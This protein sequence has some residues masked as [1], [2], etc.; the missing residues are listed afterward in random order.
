MAFPDPPRRSALV[1]RPALRSPRTVLVAGVTAAIAAAGVAGAT[2]S[3][4]VYNGCALNTTGVLRQVA[5]TTACRSTEH[6]IT[7]NS[8]G[9]AG[10]AGARGPAG[11]AGVP[12]APGPK[13]EAGPKGET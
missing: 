3:D 5:A 7:W 13:G 8:R 11:A 2:S 4:T 1:S 6:R 9:P 10:A 12:G